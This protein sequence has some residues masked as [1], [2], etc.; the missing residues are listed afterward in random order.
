MRSS[1]TGSR[2]GPRYGDHAHKKVGVTMA[3]YDSGRSWWWLEQGPWHGSGLA[4]PEVA[5]GGPLRATRRR[6]RRHGV[7]RLAMRGLGRCCGTT[8]P[9]LERHG[10]NCDGRGA[11]GPARTGKLA[12]AAT[13]ERTC[14][15]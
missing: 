1:T 2:H 11:A 3:C 12:L 10:N 8:A 13:L 9:K 7:N 5:P 4:S 14:L 6:Q 15:R